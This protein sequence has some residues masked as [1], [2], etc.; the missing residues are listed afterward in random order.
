MTQTTIDQLLDRIRSARNVE[1]ALVVQY[2]GVK[3]GADPIEN[4]RNYANL[5]SHRAVKDVLNK[6]LAE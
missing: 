3:P 4:V 5:V 6:I 2:E 1:E